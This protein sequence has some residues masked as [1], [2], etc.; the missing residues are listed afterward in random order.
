MKTILVTGAS[1]FVGHHLVKE[2]AEHSIRVI[3]TGTHPAAK[4]QKPYISE[5]LQVNL[6]NPTE[7]AKL[8]LKDVDGIVHLAGLA[9]VG[10]S[11]DDPLSYITT[12][13]GIETHL[14]EHALK[15]RAT[16]RFLVISTGALYSSKASLPLTEESST[17]PSSPYAVSKLGQEQVAQYY[18]LRGIPYIVARPF[19]HIG[20]GQNL[21]F[22]LPDL[23]KQVVDCE[24]GRAT[25]VSVGNLDAQR[26]YTD[27]RDI[28]RAYR[29][30]LEKG[31]PGEIYNI[32]SGKAIAGRFLLDTILT[33]T[34]AKPVV[35]QDP[36]RMRPS[37]SPILYGAHRKLTTDTGWEPL[38]NLQTTIADVADDWRGRE[39]TTA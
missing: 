8:P 25:Q 28:V 2:L 21:G 20:P 29:L 31:R 26:D 24:K 32:C 10:P 4:D 27:V 3:A 36:A 11:F 35:V 5:Y 7:V 18:G 12:N 23:A 39:S 17:I 9:V 38:F 30:L 19:N 6:M 1:G 13:M 37:D 33:K 14:F 34:S 22:I 15:Q 16:P